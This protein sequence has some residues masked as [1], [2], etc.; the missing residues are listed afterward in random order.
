MSQNGIEPALQRERLV[1][2]ARG[3]ELEDAGAQSR[4]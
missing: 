3:G 1:V 2:A 4:G